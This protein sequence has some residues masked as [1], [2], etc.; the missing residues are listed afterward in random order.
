M[1][2]RAFVV[3]RA[4]GRGR[5]RSRDVAGGGCVSHCAAAPAHPAPGASL[6]ELKEGEVMFPG[7]GESAEAVRVRADVRAREIRAICPAALEALGE[8]CIRDGL[9]VECARRVL[10]QELRDRE[11]AGFRAAL[12]GRV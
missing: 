7:I 8:Q 4:A 9:D 1:R 11:G 5:P 6:N 2:R 10:L 3:L 12:S